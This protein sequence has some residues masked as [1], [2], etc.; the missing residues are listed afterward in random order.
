[1]TRDSAISGLRACVDALGAMGVAS[2]SLFGSTARD[3]ADEDSDLDL[4]VGCDPGRAPP[5]LAAIKRFLDGELGVDCD[6]TIF[7]DLPPAWRD[8]V[9]REMVRL[10]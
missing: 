2:L 8:G 9:A 10:F 5:D 3:E 1:M 4:V 6:V 7:D